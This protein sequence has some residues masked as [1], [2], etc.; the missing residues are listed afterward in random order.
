MFYYRQLFFNVILLTNIHI[1]LEKTSKN[2]NS[3]RIRFLNNVG[4]KGK[5]GLNKYL[6]YFFSTTTAVPYA[7]TSVTPCMTSLDSYR[8]LMIAF[9]PRCSA[10]LI[11][12]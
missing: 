4:K 12:S 6:C 8:M 5:V 1:L 9:A 2:E 3:S 10:F 11:I 7:K